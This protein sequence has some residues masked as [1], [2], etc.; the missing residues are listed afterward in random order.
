M[1][2]A[3]KIKERKRHGRNG[4]N[5]SGIES[6]ALF[7]F[8]M[9]DSYTSVIVRDD[10]GKI[11]KAEKIVEEERRG[12]NLLEEEPHDV[13]QRSSQTD[14]NVGSRES[15]DRKNKSDLKHKG[16][17]SDAEGVG[18][19]GTSGADSKSKVRKRRTKA[20]GSG[21]IEAVG[22]DE[23]KVSGRKGRKQETEREITFTGTRGD[24]SEAS[25]T[26]GPKQIEIGPK[27]CEDELDVD[28][29]IDGTIYRV[30]RW[31]VIGNMYH[32]GLD[33]RFIVRRLKM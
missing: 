28:V 29:Q 13:E 24:F 6:I 16:L 14:V 19:K 21:D 12:I 11:T 9:D 3:V 27:D 10:T 33:S 8:G 7:D 4:E 1:P 15:D 23:Q 22:S 31:S 17:S 30:S 26:I 32:Q 2:Q 18:N 5:N 20:S 25:M